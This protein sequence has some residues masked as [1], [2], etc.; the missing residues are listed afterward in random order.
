MNLCTGNST[1]TTPRIEWKKSYVTGLDLIKAFLVVASMLIIGE[2][3]EISTRHH[4]G[5][6]VK[7]IEIIKIALE[8]AV[9]VALQKCQRIHIF[10]LRIFESTDAVS[11]AH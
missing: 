1:G 3:Q 9:L 4:L 8:Q 7:N 11:C 2:E 5:T 6:I 10:A